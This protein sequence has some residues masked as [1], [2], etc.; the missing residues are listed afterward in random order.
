MV[1]AK[2]SKAAARLT[3]QFQ[4]RTPQKTYTAILEHLPPEPTGTLTDWL[5]KDDGQRR[6]VTCEA[7]RP[8][9]RRAE[10]SYET[11]GRDRD[12][13]LVRVRLLTGRKHQIRVQFASRDMPILGD[14]KYASEHPFPRGIALHSTSLVFQ[15]PVR[16]E[17]MSFRVEPPKYWKLGRFGR[18]SAQK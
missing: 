1:F 14:R 8:G 3:K 9:A 11:L 5:V 6:M 4:T 15:H 16:L 18:K 12:Q 7:S 10:L 2:T 17:E 13:A